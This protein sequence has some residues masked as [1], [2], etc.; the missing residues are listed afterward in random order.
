MRPSDQ[1]LVHTVL[2]VLC[3]QE[4]KK[5]TRPAAAVDAA[6]V[7]T[8][9][10]RGGGGKVSHIMMSCRVACITWHHMHAH[11]HIYGHVHGGGHSGILHGPCMQ[12]CEYAR[13]HRSSCTIESMPHVMIHMCDAGRQVDSAD[14]GHRDGGGTGGQAARK[15]RKE[16]HCE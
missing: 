13:A 14:T 16:G 12:M 5:Q 11:A 9:S 1:S 6:I 7:P 3:A 8:A 2:T 15:G 4:E 10:R